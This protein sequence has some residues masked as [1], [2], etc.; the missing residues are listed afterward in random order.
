M[1]ICGNNFTNIFS[2]LGFGLSEK[3]ATVKHTCSK[4]GHVDEDEV[5]VEKNG[6]NF[7]ADPASGIG[8]MCPWKPKK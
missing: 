1:G 4:C 8:T 5:R 7:N 2:N 6:L 3:T